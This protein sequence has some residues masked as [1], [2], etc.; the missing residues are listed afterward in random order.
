MATAEE[1]EISLA[2]KTKAK[3]P[4]RKYAKRQNH[5]WLKASECG[6]VATS[7]IS[8]EEKILEFLAMSRQWFPKLYC[9]LESLHK[10]LIKSTC[11]SRIIPN[12]ISCQLK[13]FNNLKNSKIDVITNALALA[14][15]LEGKRIIQRLYSITVS[16]LR[17]LAFLSWLQILI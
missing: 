17:C 12:S 7:Q 3:R 2:S 14:Q 5:S 13:K 9:K 8:F 1:H 15:T 10:R 4:K 11:N 16:I 6:I